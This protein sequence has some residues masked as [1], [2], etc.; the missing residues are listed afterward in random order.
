[1]AEIHHTDSSKRPPWHI[2]SRSLQQAHLG[3]GLALLTLLLHFHDA[4]LWLL[5]TFASDTYD[6]WGFFPLLLTLLWVRRPQLRTTPHRGNLAGMLSVMVA[7]VMVAPLGI[8]LFSALLSV[9]ALQLCIGAFFVTHGAIW[10]RRSFWLCLL[11]LPVVH[12]C[13]GVDEC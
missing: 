1:M 4:L 7:D 9:V 13:G 11:C 10:K 12:W 2:S 6:S 3:A 5:R 8:H